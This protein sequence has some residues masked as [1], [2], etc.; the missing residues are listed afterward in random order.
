MPSVTRAYP[1][2]AEWAIWDLHVHT[3]DSIV[4]HYGNSK[5]VWDRFIQEL[6]SLPKEIK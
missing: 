3:P 1:R 4:Q 5:D 2:G 6:E